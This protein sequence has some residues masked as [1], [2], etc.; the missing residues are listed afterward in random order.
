MSQ[1]EEKP[2]RD[3]YELADVGTRLVALI[4]D[5]IILG[6][7]S[8]VLF[9]FAREPG[10]AGGFIVGLAYQWYFLTQRDGQTPGK[11]MMGIRAVKVSGEPIDFATV[12]IRYVGYYINSFAIGIGWLWALFNDKRQ[13][14]HDLLA[15]TYVV[16][17]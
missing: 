2:K 17:A 1:I 4:I 10:A 11:Q 6:L 14:W 13:G 15:G 5:G 12:L 7:I 16:R 3:Q 8:G 9:A